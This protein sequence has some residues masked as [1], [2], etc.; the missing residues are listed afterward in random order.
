[1]EA[2]FGGM[3]QQDVDWLAVFKA[4]NPVQAKDLAAT[5]DMACSVLRERGYTCATDDRA[6]KLRGALARFVT[7]SQQ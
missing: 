6:D 5:F 3:T 4:A 2:T 1:M 7:E